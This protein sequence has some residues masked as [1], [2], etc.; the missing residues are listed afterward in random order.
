MF[1]PKYNI[2]RDNIC[3]A[4]RVLNKYKIIKYY[5]STRILCLYHYKDINEKKN[6]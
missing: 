6:R 4:E 1:L 2:Y 3:G 5:I